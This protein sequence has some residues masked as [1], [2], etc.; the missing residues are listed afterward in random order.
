MKLDRCFCF[1][2]VVIL[3]FEFVKASAYSKTV[4]SITNI[5]ALVFIKQGHYV[6]QLAVFNIISSFI[7]NH[8]AHKKGNGLV[9]IIIQSSFL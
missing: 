8:I 9:H 3:G 7:G 4:K 2:F 5:P 1:D 6:L